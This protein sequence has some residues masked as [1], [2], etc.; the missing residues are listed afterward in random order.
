MLTREDLQAITEI[1]KAT[2]S[3]EVAQSEKRIMQEVGGLIQNTEGRIMKNVGGLLQD[4]EG[5]IMHN[6]GGLLQE[7]KTEIMQEV[8]GLI[9]DTEGRIMKGAAVLIDAE[10]KPKFDLLAEDISLIREKVEG[11]ENMDKLEDD[12]FA[13]KAVVKQHT[14]E[15]NQLKKAQ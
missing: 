9:Q 7:Q 5:R 8:G 4:T 15:I 14:R 10:V 1:V 6:V 3:E 12:V 13:L 11:F 2:V